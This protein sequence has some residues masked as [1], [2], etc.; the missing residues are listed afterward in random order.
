ERRGGRGR[1]GR[2]DHWQ[3]HCTGRADLC[4]GLSGCRRPVSLVV[5]ERGEWVRGGVAGR[6]RSEAAGGEGVLEAEEVEEVVRAGVV[7]V[8]VGRGG[9]ELILKAQEVEEIKLAA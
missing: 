8:G 6:P 3:S 1:Q 7:A 2:S 4:Q 5:Q 9:S